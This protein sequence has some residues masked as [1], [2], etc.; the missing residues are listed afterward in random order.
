MIGRWVQAAQTL[1]SRFLTFDTPQVPPRLVSTTRTFSAAVTR[2]KTAVLR[3][4]RLESRAG[5]RR[6][7]AAEVSAATLVQLGAALVREAQDD[8][9][10]DPVA[11]AVRARD[12][13]AILLLAYCPLRMSTFSKTPRP[14]VPP[15]QPFHARP[16]LSPQLHDA[17]CQI[18]C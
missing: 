16:R 17:V 8:P 5:A 4:Q 9:G 15:P 13:A 7:P 11:R 18:K 14:G 2:L 10:L 3:L 1:A 12:G 6:L